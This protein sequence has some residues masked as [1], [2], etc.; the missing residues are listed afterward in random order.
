LAEFVL[1]VSGLV[2]GIGTVVLFGGPLLVGLMLAWRRLARF[3]RR[4]LERFHGVPLP[5]P[6]RALTAATRLARVRERLAD[7]AA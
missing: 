6:Y 4:V 5:D 2:L 1:L 3:E 7:P